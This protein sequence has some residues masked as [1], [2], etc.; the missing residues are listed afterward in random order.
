MSASCAGDTDSLAGRRAGPGVTP[1]VRNPDTVTGG[2]GAI[3]GTPGVR[4]GV[5]Q[6]P[7]QGR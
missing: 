5:P 6:G 2:A 3:A 7:R 1:V 4:S